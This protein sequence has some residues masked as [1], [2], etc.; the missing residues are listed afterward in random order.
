VIG[1]ANRLVNASPTAIRPEA[2]ASTA[3]SGI[4]SPVAIASPEKPS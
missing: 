1:A 4:R 2:G 3:A